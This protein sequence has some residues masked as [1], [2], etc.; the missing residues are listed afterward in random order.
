MKKLTLI[1]GIAVLATLGFRISSQAPSFTAY[2]TPVTITYTITNFGETGEQVRVHTLVC[3]YRSDGSHS[4]Y[5]VADAPHFEIR[6]FEKQVFANVDPLIRAMI[7]IERPGIGAR[8]PAT[9][10]A[11]WGVGSCLGPVSNVIHGFN[12]EKVHQKDTDGFAIEYLV[13]PTL[14]FEVL[15]KTV[16]RADGSLMERWMASDVRVGDPD[17]RLFLIPDDYEILSRDIYYQR[18]LNARGRV[19]NPRTLEMFRSLDRRAF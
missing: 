15:E 16:E 13:A 6:D 17:P 2:R 3:A 7:Y 1:L 14:A 18:A 8:I 9:C 19:A 12:L 5:V 4:H 11:A 10:E